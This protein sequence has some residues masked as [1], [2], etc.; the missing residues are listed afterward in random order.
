MSEDAWIRTYSGVK[1]WP[2]DPDPYAI[3]IADIAHALS[4]Q[5]RYA[6]HVKWHY[7]VGQH[8]IL[9]SHECPEPAQLWGLMHD[10]AEAYLVDLPRPIKWKMPGYQ[11]AEERLLKLIAGK[12][13]LGWPVPDVVKELDNR[14]MHDE[15]EQLMGY[16]P[17]EA[18]GAN[19][20]GLGVTIEQQHPAYVKQQFLL[21]FRFLNGL[22]E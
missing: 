15:I 11:E 7:S 5:C 13:G 18:L 16:D 2:L 22:G 4:L 3:R 8:S 10:A 6:G 21:R 9:V 17:L 12:Y 1:F 14:M 20:R 19:S